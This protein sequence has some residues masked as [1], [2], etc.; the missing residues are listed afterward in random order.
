MTNFCEQY[1][2]WQEKCLQELQEQGHDVTMDSVE[3]CEDGQIHFRGDFYLTDPLVTPWKD[4]EFYVD[5][6]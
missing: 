1:E 5:W 3:I 4:S 6:Q 2:K